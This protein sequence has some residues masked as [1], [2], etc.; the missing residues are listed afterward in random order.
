[1]PRQ[2][3]TTKQ[4]VASEP[5]PVASEPVQ[6]VDTKQKKAPAKRASK[7]KEVVAEPVV[8]STDE[9]V[10]EDVS[11]VESSATT[12]TETKTRVAP[13]RESVLEGLDVIINSVDAEITRLRGTQNKAKGVKFLRSLNKHLKTHRS[14]ASRVMKQKQRTNRK[15]NTNSGFLKPVRIS[16]AM[17]KFTGWNPDELQ[18]RVSVTKFLC[19]YI[20]EN[21]L[22]NPTD[23]RQIQADAKLAKLLNYDAKKDTEPLTYY[24]IQS[25]IKQHFIKDE[26][27]AAAV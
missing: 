22:Q 27:K 24:K 1:M 17:S 7:K 3:K 4:S 2:P 5:E 8:A 10:E 23:R 9:V 21:E 15:N 25:Y 12:A 19:N 14:Q 16:A 26:P 11:D 20:R 18:S 13:T 6:K